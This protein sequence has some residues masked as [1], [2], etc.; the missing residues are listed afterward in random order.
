MR[1]RLDYLVD[2]S[3]SDD[4]EPA[5]EQEG[6]DLLAAEVNREIERFESR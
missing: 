2:L 1:E 5:I 3:L 6:I 4:F